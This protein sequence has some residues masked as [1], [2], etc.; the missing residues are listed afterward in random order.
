M[1]THF[2][3][4]TLNT[5]IHAFA[6]ASKSNAH[7]A[8]SCTPVHDVLVQEALLYAQG[9]PSDFYVSEDHR[10]GFIVRHDGE[11]CAVF[12]SVRGR[13]AD[14]VRNAIYR[15]ATKL[16]HYEGYLS[17]FYESHGFILVGSEQNYNGPHL[18][19]VEYRALRG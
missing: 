2:N 1:T 12:S 5:F 14:L 8:E 10:S 11:L 9:K 15:G 19:R 16:D 18:P 6:T 17:A 7:I 13:G 4:T 3:T